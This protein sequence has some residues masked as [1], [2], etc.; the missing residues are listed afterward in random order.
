MYL[1]CC[2]F[3]N[4]DCLWETK[5]P[6]RNSTPIVKL[7]RDSRRA[8]RQWKRTKL[9]VHHDI[10]KTHLTM[11]NNA[12]SSARKA[13]F[14]VQ[15]T[16][17]K[18]TLDTYSLLSIGYL[19]PLLNYQQNF[20][21]VQSAMSLYNFLYNCIIFYLSNREYCV[22]LGTYTSRC[23]AISCGVPQTRQPYHPAAQDRLPTEAKQGWAWSVP[24]WE[25]SWEI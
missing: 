17:T 9:T 2:T 15:L 18:T 11:L 8:E 19:N 4:K 25:T 7:R 5:T 20:S 3:K 16:A 14:Q 21:Q 10:Y 1:L 23:Y 6:W 22:T 24:G 13:Y 12:T